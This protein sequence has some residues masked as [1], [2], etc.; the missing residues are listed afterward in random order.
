VEKYGR[1]GE[2]T[3]DYNTTAIF[4]LCCL[5]KYLQR[6]EEQFAQQLEDQEQVFGPSLPLPADLPDL[7][8]HDH[9]HHIGSTRSS[10][11]SVSEG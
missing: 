9:A 1:T 2:A 10:L 6:L 3:D 11:S 4:I 5:L 8:I 7:P